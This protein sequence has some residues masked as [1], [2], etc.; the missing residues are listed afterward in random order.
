M[1]IR[2]ASLVLLLTSLAAGC[3][4]EDR[5]GSAAYFDGQSCRVCPKTARLARGGC[6]CQDRRNYEFRDY[7]CQ[8]RDGAVLELD[9]DAATADAA[10]SCEAYCDFVGLCIGQNQLAS[11]ALPD[12]QMGLHAGDPKACLAAC[13][14]DNPDQSAQPI[15]AC[16]QAGRS[17]ANCES[18][19]TDD[20]RLMG[21]FALIG[22]CCQG[23]QQALCGSI[24]EV[25]EA[26]QSLAQLI[27]FCD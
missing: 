4:P 20:G 3:Q 22:A 23:Q 5:C 26:N 14:R 27:D 7:R 25:L 19:G 15:L 24:C 6:V 8:L 10:S 2:L 17:A 11:S 1:Q 16:I 12:V 9:A 13:G 18:D 21:A